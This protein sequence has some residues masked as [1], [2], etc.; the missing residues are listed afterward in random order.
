MVGNLLF[1]M[2]QCPMLCVCTRSLT[3]FHCYL[4]GEYSYCLWL[5]KQ[6]L[7]SCSVSWHPA[8][9][10]KTTLQVFQVYRELWWLGSVMASASD[11]WSEGRGFDSRP[12]HCQATTLGMLFTPIVPLS[13]SSIIWYLVWAFV[14]RA[15][16]VAAMH[17]SSEQGEYCRAVLQRSW[18]LR[19]A[20]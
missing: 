19:T 3:V 10:R 1:T 16:Y 4:A 8:V 12:V 20:I 11:L 15:S 2:L 18:L 7:W 13:P 14:L 17:G 9:I 6:W 5:L